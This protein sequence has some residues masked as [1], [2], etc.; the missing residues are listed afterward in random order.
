MRNEEHLGKNKTSHILK[1]L[2]ENRPCRQVSNFDCF[3][4]IDHEN[5]QF[6]FQLKEV[7]NI[8]WKKSISS[9][10]IKHVTLIISI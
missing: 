10:Q 2:K 8:N 5:S 9:K 7:M 1:H 4:I 3:G 6:M